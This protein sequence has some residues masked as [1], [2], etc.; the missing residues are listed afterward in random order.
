MVVIQSTISPWDGGYSDSD[1]LTDEASAI[2]TPSPTLSLKKVKQELDPDYKE[3]TGKRHKL[4]AEEIETGP[5]TR[6]QWL[7]EH[8]EHPGRR[9][10]LIV[11]LDVPNLGSVIPD[12]STPK[13]EGKAGCE[14]ETNA[15]G[16]GGGDMLER[17]VCV[18]RSSHS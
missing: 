3:L 5:T 18:P 6:R 1:S 16:D 7:Q 15:V 4:D 9:K 12:S 8:P 17:N 11:C 13:F 2:L 14:A 10:S